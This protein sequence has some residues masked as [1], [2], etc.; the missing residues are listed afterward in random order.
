ML[1]TRPNKP[2]LHLG[3]QGYWPLRLPLRLHGLELAKH[4]HI[5][6]T[7]GV[8]KSKFNAHVAVSLIQNGYPC[9]VIDPHADLVHD[10]LGLLH[11]NGFFRQPAAF[12]KLWYVEF[13]RPDRVIPFNVLRQP[14]SVQT[15]VRNHLEA[16]FRTWPA[17]DGGAAPQF[18]NI[19][20]Y[21]AMVLSQNSLPI[22]HS[23]RLLTNRDERERLLANCTHPPTCEFFHDRYDQWDER[24][25]TQNVESFLRRISIFTFTDTMRFGLGHTDNQLNFRRFLDE[26][27]SVL[28]NIGNL[29]KE[30]R[31]L[32]GSLLMV[33]F[34]Q[35]TLSRADIPENKRQPY[36]ILIDEFPQFSS[37]S[38]E[39]FTT[40]LSEARKFHVTLW[41]SHQTGAQISERFQSA[42]QNALPI[43]FRVGR[44]DSLWAAQ[45][46]GRYDPYRVKHTVS[47]VAAEERTHPVF[48]GLPEQV[49]EMAKSF[50]DLRPQEAFIKLAK[51][52]SFQRGSRVIKFKTH[53]LRK[54]YS[55]ATIQALR[56]TYAKLLL[57]PIP[58]ATAP[59]PEHETQ[60]VFSKRTR[61]GYAS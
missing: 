14:Y 5:M 43:F 41:L 2:L 18:E 10:I 35:A 8:G 30:T 20:Q 47:D 6:G 34:E 54:Y 39:A 29:D 58:A 59:P 27:Q 33:G 48:W 40:F 3:N 49:E 60:P 1:S 44:P 12:Q 57:S 15:T 24:E 23:T 50:E 26:G 19:L 22:T 55:D 53:T 13:S 61:F 21:S 37:R 7:T 9:S 51:R 16:C 52:F 38:E 25:R 36:H 4:K 28:F 17:L 46:F 42:M 11:Q 32:L 31:H 45:I 56:E